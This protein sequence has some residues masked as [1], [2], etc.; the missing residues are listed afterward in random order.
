MDD[1][2]EAERHANYGG[3]G[4]Q[5][6]CRSQGGPASEEIHCRRGRKYN[7]GPLSITVLDST[8]RGVRIKVEGNVDNPAG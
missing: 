7:L 3:E 1:I 8:I 6:S 2:T 4:W 5:G